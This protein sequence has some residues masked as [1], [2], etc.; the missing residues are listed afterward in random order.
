MMPYADQSFNSQNLTAGQIAIEQRSGSTGR[1]TA[2]Q[3]N[4]AA[5]IAQAEPWV[6]QSG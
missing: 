1:T 3:K 5:T 2:G 4:M 6:I